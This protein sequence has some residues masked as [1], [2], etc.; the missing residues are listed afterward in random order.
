MGVLD[1]Q[2]VDIDIDIK[3]AQAIKNIVLEV[4]VKDGIISKENAEVYCRDY[5]V[6]IIKRSWWHN[7]RDIF[8]KDA[9]DGYHYRFVKIN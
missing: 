3:N 5:Q 6:V 9:S 7:W 4:L 8:G 2:L 1:S